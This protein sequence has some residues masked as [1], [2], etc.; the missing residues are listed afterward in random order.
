[1]IIAEQNV[2][3][4]EGKVDRIIGMHAG[5]L[6]GEGFFIISMGLKN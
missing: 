6:K 3:L 2:A 4:L 1:M 5:K